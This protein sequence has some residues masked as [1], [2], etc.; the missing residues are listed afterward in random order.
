[1]SRA[2]RAKLQTVGTTL[3]IEKMVYGGEGLARKERQVVLLP[4]VLPGERV[5]AG[6]FERSGGVMRAHPDQVLDKS[7]DRVTA[8]CP[9][10]GRC[11]GC[12]YQ[13]GTYEA[14]LNWK[15][16][17]L[18][19]TLQRV[20]KINAPDQIQVIAGEPW[21][22]RNRVQ[23]HSD[24]ERLGYQEAGSRKLCPIDHCPISSP[25]INDAIG[26][27]SRMIRDR[28]WPRFVKS[29]E[30][31]TNESGLQVNVLESSRPVAKHFFDWC[32]EQIPGFVPGPLDYTAGD[33][34]YQVSGRS[35]FQVN[36]FLVQQLVDDVIGD[37]SGGEA[38]D[39][40]SGVGLFSLPL[41]RRFGRVMAVE[42]GAGAV[43]DL[44][45]NSGRAGLSIEVHQSNAEAFLDQARATADFVL[46]DPPRAGLGKRAVR[47]LLELRPRLLTI[48]ACDPA[49]LAR[50]LALL[51]Q[52]GY[53]L[54][55]L[56]LIDLF[57][58]T[59]HIESIARCRI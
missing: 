19:E 41:A 27:L 24:G 43:R 50:D 3:D 36:R 30:L 25:K 59:Y 15:R 55:Q 2:G 16:A 45:H 21:N 8:P 46:A 58:Q 17:I 20:G 49:T 11:G 53:H 6:E 7:R 40:Y 1:L 10:F 29:L 9:Y 22:Y 4:F 13:H 33:F 51:I 26:I 54:D 57:P 47:R 39:L 37:A 28:R 14:Q 42:S 44:L 34:C 5:E 23:L 38:M 48:V 31:F 18:A 56:S 52:G 32:A 12:Q 35:F